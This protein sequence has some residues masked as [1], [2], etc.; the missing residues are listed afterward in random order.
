MSNLLKILD[1][2]LTEK[3]RIDYVSDNSLDIKE[4]T[5]FFATKGLQTH[6]SKYI[7]DALDRGAVLVLHNDPCYEKVNIKKNIIYKKNLDNLIVDFLFKFYQL[8]KEYLKIHGFTGTNG[9]TTTSYLASQANREYFKRDSI[10]F[11]TLGLKFN[12]MWHRTTFK[13]DRKGLTTPNIFDFFKSINSVIN[14]EKQTDV[15]LEI[16]SHAIDQKRLK[17][18]EFES[19]S[20]L[21]IGKDHLDYHKNYKNYV[22]TKFDI[23]NFKAKRKIINLDCKNIKDHLIKNKNFKKN[24]FSVSNKVCNA[25]YYYDISAEDNL[26]SNIC[27]NRSYF[28]S[29]RLIPEFN[30]TNLIHAL[31]A[32]NFFNQVRKKHI[33]LNYL[34]LP[35][36]RTEIIEDIPINVIIDFAHNHEGFENFLSS[37]KKYFPNLI[38]VFGCGGNRDREKRPMMMRTAL[39]YGKKV[40]FTSDNSRNEKFDDI[41][42]DA[43]KN[44]KTKNVEV[45]K[46]RQVA[47]NK[48]IKEIQ[49]ND[50]LVILGK[51]HEET[52]EEN[53]KIRFFSD[54]QVVNN[55]FK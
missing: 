2:K 28:I 19:L 49:D 47:I 1:I 36:G 9:K 39:H 50:C 45:I 14:K 25:N 40:F 15:F 18:L 26:S 38:I 30:L 43:L 37:I 12:D 10:Y 46:D 27:I 24:F 16:S 13:E 22:K 21:N 23:F 34:K 32:I 4:N 41:C 54:K 42:T 53:G 35:S 7:E 20:L 3:L 6:G 5:I 51:G 17:T 11:G 52:Q 44:N 55:V 29:S 48:A 33:D 8:K 31:A